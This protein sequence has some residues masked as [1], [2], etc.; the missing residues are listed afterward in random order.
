MVG[1]REIKNGFTENSI[2]A[3]ISYACLAL[4][5]LVSGCG[6][7]A[8]KDTRAADESALRDLD[9]QWSKTAAARDVDATVSYY[10]DDASLLAPNAPAVSGKQGIHASWA[11]L[12]G[13]DTSLSWQASKVDVARSGDLAYVMGVYQLTT[14][15]AH[16]NFTTDRG[17]YVEVWKKQADG[18]WKTVAD[19]FNTDLPAQ[20]PTPTPTSEKKKSHHHR[21]GKRTRRS[22]RSTGT[23]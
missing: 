14:K 9:A 5:L 23:Q 15:D 1:H 21:S 19:I 10:S 11:A 16:A 22:S 6:Q 3:A 12:L 4:V 20:A 2:Q 13:P 7:Q 17:K 8:P 18:T